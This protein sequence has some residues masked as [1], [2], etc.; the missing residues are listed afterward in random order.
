M[1]LRDWQKK[2]WLTEH[3]TSP[4]EI[5]GLIGVIERDLSDSRV[6]GLSPDWK[7][8]IAYNAALQA[9]TIALYACGFRASREAH[10]LRVIQSLKFTIKADKEIIDQLDQFRKKRNISDYESAGQVSD[11]EAS[12]MLELAIFL[13]DTVK[14]WLSENSPE[15]IE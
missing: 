12:E 7:M 6:S 2:K 13:R 11:S 15:L 14:E 8:N 4:A 1:S 3:A 9:A 5:S 10:H